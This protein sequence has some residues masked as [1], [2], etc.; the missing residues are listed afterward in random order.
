MRGFK[1]D[2]LDSGNPLANNVLSGLDFW[3]A[4]IGVAVRS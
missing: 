3:R 2:T 1:G 4:N